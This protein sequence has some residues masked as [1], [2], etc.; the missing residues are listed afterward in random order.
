MTEHRG[1]ETRPDLTKQESRNPLSKADTRAEGNTPGNSSKSRQETL[2]QL[3]DEFVSRLRAGEKPSI[4]EYQERYPELSSEIDDVL[5]SVAMIENL[6]LQQET[7]GTSRRKRFDKTTFERIG[8]YKIV[9]E[10]GRGGMG[11]V[12]EAIHESLGRRVA[13]KLLP[14]RVIEDDDALLRF[15]KEARAAA[16]LH[17]SNIVNVFGVGEHEGYHYYVMEH[18]NGQSLADWI[19]RVLDAKHKSG[20]LETSDAD[21]QPAKGNPDFQD[22]YS[23]YRWSASGMAAIAD[24]L[25]YSHANKILHRDIKPSNLLVDQ[26]LKLWITDFGLVKELSNQTMTGTGDI[27][28]TPQY[29]APESLEGK[30]DQRSEVYCLGLTLYELLVLRPA[31]SDASPT[32]LFKR[33][34]TSSPKPLRQVDPGIPRDL[35]TIVQRATDRDPARRYQSA[36]ELRDDLNRFVADEPIKARRIL[37]VE[38]AYRWARRNPLTASL[39]ALSAFLLLLLATISSYAYYSTNQALTALASKHRDLQNEK[40]KTEDAKELAEQNEQKM[41]A[42]YE[43]AEGNVELSIEAFDK[44]F[45]RIMTKGVGRDVKA[46]LELETYSELSTLEST[47]TRDD[48]RILQSAIEYYEQFTERNQDNEKLRL[49]IAKAYRRIA[50]THHFLGSFSS[51]QRGYTK[52]IEAYLNIIKDKPDDLVSVVNLAETYN[53][54]GLAYRKQGK[55]PIGMKEHEN[56]RR[57]LQKEIYQSEESCQFT[58]ANTLIHLCTFSRGFNANRIRPWR[59]DAPQ[60]PRQALG[61]FLRIVPKRAGL[62]REAEKISQEL[63]R[64]Q[65]KNPDYRLQRAKLFQAKATIFGVDGETKIEVKQL[66]ESITELKSLVQ[67]FPDN[68]NYSFTLAHVYTIR[69]RNVADETQ[70]QMQEEARKICAQLVDKYPSVI[71]Y[72]DL[73][74]SVSLKL[75]SL[76]AKANETKKAIGLLEEATEFYMSLVRKSPY[77]LSH[78]LQYATSVERLA[79]AYDAD[80]DPGQAR[81][82]WQTLIRLIQNAPALARNRTR[83]IELLDKA[84]EELRKLRSRND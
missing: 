38:R 2:D 30:Y 26:K 81:A 41:R 3:A 66:Q 43:R 68:P 19:R 54:L 59:T 83:K 15:R 53:E 22:D 34:A 62:L 42:E 84:R 69:L 49:E 74:A 64:S 77:V 60:L 36:G 80:G 12:F 72:L 18:V 28:G 78:Y 40:Q 13:I 51:A 32:Q 21:D 9:R 65:P 7:V 11:I 16:K 61:E 58:L 70:I 67:D 76:Y 10:L 27:F 50:N 39:V 14:S 46:N 48:A 55:L 71:E 5:G 56:A 79:Q 45:V 47:V 23:R 75:G 44:L 8:D 63:L 29:L 35:E 73:A 24:A 31:Y 4:K 25:E 82:E 1:D 57:L 20:N 6:K 33:I 52:A 37:P 17:H